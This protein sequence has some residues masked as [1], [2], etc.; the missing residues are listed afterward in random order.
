M[1]DVFLGQPGGS[2]GNNGGTILGPEPFPQLEVKDRFLNWRLKTFIGGKKPKGLQD[3]E[4]FDPHTPQIECTVHTKRSQHRYSHPLS[5][6]GPAPSWRG[7][8]CLV[9]P[10]GEAWRS[11]LG[12]HARGAIKRPRPI[13]AE[14]QIGT[15]YSRVRSFA[16]TTMVRRVCGMTCL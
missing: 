9:N 3:L 12:W 2:Q 5:R 13:R 14:Q 4:T 15:D 6:G 7:H 11:E 8:N 16:N 1:S 10:N